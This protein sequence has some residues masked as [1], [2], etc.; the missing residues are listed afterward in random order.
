MAEMLVTRVFRIGLLRSLVLVPVLSQQ[1]PQDTEED[2]EEKN[3]LVRSLRGG[4][5]WARGERR[6]RCLGNL[7]DRRRNKNDDAELASS[8]LR[9]PKILSAMEK[10]N[11]WN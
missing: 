4:K 10:R 9:F 5:D 7:E 8:L 1:E 11:A 3:N 6:E 2:T